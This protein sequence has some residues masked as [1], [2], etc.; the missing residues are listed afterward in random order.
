M[1]PHKRK[2]FQFSLRTLLLAALL[3]SIAWTM[4]A[5]VGASDLQTYLSSGYERDY[6]DSKLN[7]WDRRT[8]DRPT[9]PYYY[10]EAENSCLPCIL[11]VNHGVMLASL[12]GDGGTTYYVWFLWVK[13][14]VYQTDSW[15]S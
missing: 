15:L 8:A 1:E 3:L 12:C 9:M 14:P 2:R 11:K 7:R 10:V 6:A 13:F 4:A 5:T